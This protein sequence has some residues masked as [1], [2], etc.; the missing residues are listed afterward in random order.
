M[1][2][3]ESLT[4]PQLD[5][6]ESVGFW[7]KI[8]LNLHTRVRIA[9]REDGPVH[10]A[11][12]GTR[13]PY[14]VTG[15]GAGFLMCWRNDVRWN[16]HTSDDPKRVLS[17]DSREYVLAIPDYSHEARDERRDRSDSDSLA[18]QRNHVSAAAFKKVVMKLQGNVQWL[19]GL[20]L[21]RAIQDNQRSFGFRPHYD[22]V[23]R[24]PQHAKSQDGLPYDAFRG[25]RSQHIHLS[26]AVRAPA[27]RDWSASGPSGDI[28]P[29]YN[30]VHATPRFFTHFFDWWSLFSGPLSLPVR[31]GALWPGRE[32][33]SKK[34]GRHLATFKYNLLL[35]PLYLSHIYKHKDVADLSSNLVSATG[36]KVRFDNWMLD[37]HQRREEFNTRDCGRKT[38]SKTSGMK[39]HAGQLD[40]VSADIRA[41]SATIRSTTEEA[42]NSGDPSA[43]IT[44]QGEAGADPSR[45]DIPDQDPHWIDADDFVELDWILPTEPNPEAKIL[46]LA[47]APRITYFRQTDI[48]GV[49]EGDPDR[50]SP[51][52]NEPTHFCVMSQDDDPR[53]VQGH[54]IDQRLGQLGQQLDTHGQTLDR[55]Q[56]RLV[57]ND[58][59]DDFRSQYDIVNRHTV[60]LREKREFLQQML[61]ETLLASPSDSLYHANSATATPDANLSPPGAEFAS[62]F[63]NRFVVHNLQLKW[64]NT[65]RNIILRYIHLVSQ[66]RGFVYYLSRPAVKFI[67]DIV[68]EQMKSK[69]AKTGNGSSPSS[70][71]PNGSSVDRETQKDIEDRIRKILQDGRKFVNAE[72]GGRQTGPLNP[73]MADLIGG[74]ADEFTTQ[75]SYHARVIAPQIQLQCDKNTKH[76]VIITAKGMDLKVVEVLDKARISDNVSG[77]VQRRFLLN[78]D[79]TQFFV[80]HQAW[81]STKLVSMYSGNTYGCPFGSSWPP[82]VPMEVMYDFESDPWGFKRVVQKTSAMLRYDKYNT[83]RLKYNDEVNVEAESAHASSHENTESRMDF[84]WV[85]FPR[86]YA[87]CNSSQYYAMYVIVLDLLLY[88]E[89]SEKTR[90]ERLEKIMLASDFS[91][92]RGAPEMVMKLQE[93]VRQLEDIKTHFQIHAQ[94]LDTKGWQDRV[95]LE[96][97]LAA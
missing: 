64:N 76:V 42:I 45:F 54:L 94:D 51:F 69:S 57:R 1:I 79:G 7:D 16:I 23:L 22:V 82:W 9:W 35:A 58:H 25:F 12:K 93:R 39:I 44:A 74:L 11:L 71:T 19:G 91:D 55:L 72:D 27:D 32:R 66:R 85:D 67:L 8:R 61:R 78:M 30:S 90:S 86:L 31:Q 89:P 26:I 60:V 29:S 28:L 97:D 18:G 68:E 84:L 56:Q 48:D 21:E 40:L 13:D 41:V 4:K 38:G 24:A 2:I 92:L 70:A 95:L 34:F 63:K 83:L 65:L 14:N 73:A 15:H 6:S 87:L 88:S 5:P 50:R 46:P 3:I 75:N 49:I 17:V 10:F 52:G 53:R 37:L 36:L 77:L 62:D 80:T 43:F 33:S 47:F 59:G 81:F 20:V 96:R